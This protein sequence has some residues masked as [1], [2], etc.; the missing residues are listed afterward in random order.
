MKN[1]ME[2]KPTPES[3]KEAI[4]TEF[5]FLVDSYGFSEVS[6]MPPSDDIYSEVH[7]E[8]KNWKIAILT[9]AHGT[10]VSLQLILPDGIR[11]FLSHLFEPEL[12]KSSKNKF[13][14]NIYDDIK[15]ESQCLLNYGS[16]LLKGETIDFERV[17]GTITNK[18]QQWAMDTGIL[19]KA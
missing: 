16:M 14:G 12:S 19:T 17:L 6:A 13:G 11:G 3:I 8:K 10:K 5:A 18:Q 1:R 2:N 7:F 4:K 15:Y 9:T